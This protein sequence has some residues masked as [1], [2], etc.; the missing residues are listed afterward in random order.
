MSVEKTVRSREI[1]EH[2]E[3]LPTYI[4]HFHNQIRKHTIFKGPVSINL[5]DSTAIVIQVLK[6][7]PERNNVWMWM[8]AKHVSTRAVIMEDVKTF[9]AISF[10]IV[11]TDTNRIRMVITAGTSMNV[12]DM[13]WRYVLRQASSKN[14]FI[15]FYRKQN[16]T[17]ILRYVII[18]AT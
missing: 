6:W 17:K 2:F 10:V 1:C 13:I 3:V 18:T 15:T 12:Q 14:E 4:N 7:N 11:L 9:L 16:K 8:S 5:V